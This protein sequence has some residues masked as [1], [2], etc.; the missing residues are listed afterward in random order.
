MVCFSKHVWLSKVLI[1]T[2]FTLLFP[3]R[4]SSPQ[5]RSVLSVHLYRGPR[6][7]SAHSRYFLAAQKV[8][9]L[10]SPWDPKEL[11]RTES[12]SLFILSSY[13]GFLI[14]YLYVKCTYFR[15]IFVKLNQYSLMVNYFVI[16]F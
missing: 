12:F 7:T 8:K 6:I 10:Y 14:L 3:M 1:R 4:M 13:F 5:E 16:Y 2:G 15:V 11:G 9:R